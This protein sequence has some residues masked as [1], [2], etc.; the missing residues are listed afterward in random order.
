MQALRGLLEQPAVETVTQAEAVDQTDHHRRRHEIARAVAP[1]QQGLGA[2]ALCAGEV[3]L[4][5]QP[6]LELRPA[7]KSRPQVALEQ[8][9]V[10]RAALHRGLEEQASAV[11]TPGNQAGDARRLQQME[12]VLAVV[13]RYRRATNHAH[14][15]LEP[16]DR[17]RAVVE[18]LLEAQHAEREHRGAGHPGQHD[19][20]LL[21]IDREQAVA[22][23]QLGAD[24]TLHGAL[25]AAQVL[26][27]KPIER[28]VGLGIEGDHADPVSF[29]PDLGQARR[30]LGEC[31]EKA[32]R[33]QRIH[34]QAR[35]KSLGSMPKALG[36]SACT[37]R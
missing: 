27:R 32:V 22:A 8:R 35:K 10:G 24:P 37:M 17:Q 13:G 14:R 5:L 9:D 2:A 31:G 15:R 23:A 3:D 1:A 20:P 30:D 29:V 36:G 4:G 6:E 25:E 12:A 28:R 18:G 16:V 34:V 7:G 26:E 33:D 19:Q 21:A 11:C